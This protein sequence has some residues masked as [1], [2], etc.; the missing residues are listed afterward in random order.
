MSIY[1]HPATRKHI[2][3]T[4]HVAFA[5]AN[6][7]VVLDFSSDTDTLGNSTC[8]PSKMLPLRANTENRF[9]PLVF[10]RAA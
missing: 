1:V 2:N 4:S 6:S 5:Q 7:S 8:A 9:R 10:C 3:R